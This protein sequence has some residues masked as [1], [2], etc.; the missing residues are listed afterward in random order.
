MRPFLA[1]ARVRRFSIFAFTSSPNLDNSLVH[2]ELRVNISPFSFHPLRSKKSNSTNCK[3]TAYTVGEGEHSLYL[4]PQTPQT[5][6]LNG[7]GEGVKAKI[8]N[9]LCTRTRAQGVANRL[10]LLLHLHTSSRKVL[11]FF[12]I[13]PF[14]S[15]K[16]PC[17]PSKHSKEYEK[18]KK[19]LTKVSI[20]KKRFSFVFSEKKRTFAANLLKFALRP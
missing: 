2:C 3:T 1:R 12:N 6:V 14:F 8:E 7:L 13:L 16:V 5:Q 9:R 10:S 17:F 19:H 11:H 18:H 4:H 15:E 20:Q